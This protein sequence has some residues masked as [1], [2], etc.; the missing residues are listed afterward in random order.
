[1]FTKAESVLDYIDAD[2]VVLAEYMKSFAMSRVNNA[3]APIKA[4]PNYEY[5]Y[6]NPFGSGRIGFLNLPQDQ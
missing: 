5:D 3:N 2:Y 4:H 6:E 1:M